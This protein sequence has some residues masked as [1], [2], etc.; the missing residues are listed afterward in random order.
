MSGSKE[1]SFHATEPPCPNSEA[2]GFR[3]PFTG[4]KQHNFYLLNPYNYNVA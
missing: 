2:W 3:L 1:R 4:R